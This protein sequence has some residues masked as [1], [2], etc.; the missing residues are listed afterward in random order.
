MHDLA[1]LT[2]LGAPAP[3]C[4]D[5]GPLRIAETPDR[6][7]ASVSARLGQEAA[8]KTALGALI[9]ADA[10]DI[11]RY[12][13]G[14]PLNSFWIGPHSWMLEAPYAGHSDLAARAKARLGD[15]ASVTDQSDA[16]ARFDLTGEG[17]ARVMERLCNLDLAAMAAGTA[18]RSVVAHIGC[19]VIGHDSAHATLYGPRS[20]A[21]S[22]HQALIM[23][24]K[25]VF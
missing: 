16:W 13:G 10:P 23:A 14:T 19:H 4:D 20:S 21:Q 1:P 7:L 22:L 12:T 24:A 17:I 2:P 11:A 6:A 8:C 9:G 5:I 25:S 18:R 15:C 3:H